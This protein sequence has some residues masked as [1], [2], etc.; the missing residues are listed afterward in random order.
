MFI[1]TYV[2]C[3]HT[4]GYYGNRDWKDL[5]LLEKSIVNLH[6]RS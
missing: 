6:L 2:H 4:N 1:I 5:L 3:Y